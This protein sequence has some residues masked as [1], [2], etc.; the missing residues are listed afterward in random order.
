MDKAM[1]LERGHLHASL[2]AVSNLFTSP[3]APTPQ[4]LLVF[5]YGEN[6]DPVGCSHGLLLDRDLFSFRAIATAEADDDRS[7]DEGDDEPDNE[8]ED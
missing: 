7:D 8:K 1:E 3:L 4:S 2:D 5:P 6:P